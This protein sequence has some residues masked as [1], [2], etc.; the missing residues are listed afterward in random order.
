M[1]NCLSVL[2]AVLVVPSTDSGIEAAAKSDPQDWPNQLRRT[3]A[4]GGAQ[5]HEARR[6][7]L[8]DRASNLAFRAVSAASM[9][10]ARGAAQVKRR[11]SGMAV[12]F[13]K[14]SLPNR[15]KFSEKLKIKSAEHDTA[16]NSDLTTDTQDRGNDLTTGTQDK[17][18]AQMLTQTKKKLTVLE[19]QKAWMEK[20]FKSVEL[21]ARVQ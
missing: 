15:S 7:L 18:N 16:S 11:L 17:G 12:L 1:L 20:F 19:F 4:V 5:H 21:H 8:R 2:F 10:R 3:A 6:E 9:S 13:S 14:M